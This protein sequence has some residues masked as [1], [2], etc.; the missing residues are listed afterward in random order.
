VYN[1]FLANVANFWNTTGTLSGNFWFS[2]NWTNGNGASA[3]IK[4]LQC[5][6][7]NVQAINPTSG[8]ILVYDSY[9]CGAN[10]GDLGLWAFGG[11]G[12][13]GTPLGRTNY[14][15]VSGWLGNYTGS[16]LTSY[17]VGIYYDNSATK[18]V[19][20]ADGTSNTLAFGESLFGNASMNRDY[21][22][23]WVAGLALGTAFGLRSSP[24]WTNYSSLHDGV[25]NFAMCDGSVHG[26]LKSVDG[27]TLNYAAGMMD[28]NTFNAAVLFGN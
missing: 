17:C 1:Q 20:I 24:D 27:N 14:A 2:W 10:C 28:G 13:Y 9:S 6:A 12:P 11:S 25:I 15:A 4:T 3:V 23:N 22:A 21:V 8:N 7:D 19:Q 5:P 18:L 16:P 26:I